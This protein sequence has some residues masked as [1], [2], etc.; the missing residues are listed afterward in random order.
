[1]IVAAEMLRVECRTCGRETMLAGRY[2]RP[3]REM[4][5]GPDGPY[6]TSERC[7]GSGDQ[8]CLT[9][10]GWADDCGC[11]APSRP[12]PRAER[13]PARTPAAR[14]ARTSTAGRLSCGC[15]PGERWYRCQHCQ[16]SRCPGHRGLRH[17]GSGS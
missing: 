8:Y 13:A 10:S 5:V 14:P 6:R 15:P 11:A 7:D 9:C 4:R 3:H 12:E 17:C 2:V 1:M 16:H